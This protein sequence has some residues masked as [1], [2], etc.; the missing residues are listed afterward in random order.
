MKCQNCNA[1]EANVHVTKII[2]GVKNE[3]HLC[4][5]CAKQKQE[6]GINTMSFG[7]PMSFQNIVDGLFEVIGTPQPINGQGEACNICGM[8]FEGFR[9]NGRVGCSNCYNTFSKNMLPLIKRVHGNIQHTGKI[10][11]RTGGMIR[12]RRD[13]EKLKEELRSLVE[14]EEY[15]KAALVRDEIRN[16][17]NELN[18]FGRQV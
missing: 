16:L 2:N 6:F 8:T 13:V 7:F 4:E 10:P 17:E 15:E 1:R 5:D 14:N 11:K 3:M 9:K 18:N 12:V